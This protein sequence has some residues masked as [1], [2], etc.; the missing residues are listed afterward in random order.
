MKSRTIVAALSALLMSGVLAEAGAQNAIT[1]TGSVGIEAHRQMYREPSIDVTEDGWFGGLTLDGQAEYQLWQL[2]ADALFVY[3]RMNY[4]GSGTVDGIDDVE[5]EGRIA[6]GRAIPVGAEG[7][8]RIT[9]YFGYGYRRL[10]D[11]LGGKVSSTGAHGYDR[12][13]QYHY[14]PIGIEGQFRLGDAWSI[15]PM[16]EYDHLIRG[17]QDSYLSQAVAGLGDVHNTQ[18]SGYGVRGSLMAGTTAW[19]WPIEFG[20]FVRYWNIKQSDTRPVTFRGVTV[21]GGFE[22]ANHSIEVG[23]AL[24]VRF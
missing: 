6:I 22:P 20:P 8:N 1:Y 7:R 11:Y 2:R 13:S 3:G 14:V 17:T 16:I 18:H 24:K 5:L 4:S 10:L 21:I 9:P 19:S 23:L 12:L 15:K